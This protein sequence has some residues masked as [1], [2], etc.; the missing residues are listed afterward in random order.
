MERKIQTQDKGITII[1][2]VITII[3]LLIL[4]GI[5][6][7]MISANSGI[8]S[9]TEKAKIVTEYSSYK[10]AMELAEANDVLKRNLEPDRIET[11]LTYNILYGTRIKEVIPN[12][13]EDI[14]E[15]IISIDGEIIY[16]ADEFNEDTES[17]E[18]IGYKIVS[19]SDI[20]YMIELEMIENLIALS[21][22]YDYLEIGKEV[23]TIAYPSSIY[24]VGLK[25]GDGWNVLGDG[26][27]DGNNTNILRE[28]EE[29]GKFILTDEEK[30]Y[31]KNSP[32][33]INYQENDY[34]LSIKG[35]DTQGEINY[36]YS[37]NYPIPIGYISNNIYAAVTEKSEKTEENYGQFI[38]VN[39][40]EALQ[41]TE[42][43]YGN[44][45]LVANG[46]PVAMPLSDEEVNIN[47]QYTLSV[48]INGTTNQKTTSGTGSTVF[49]PDGRKYYGATIIAISSGME[50]Y[51]AWISMAEGY[52]RVYV[53][54]TINISKGFTYV[55]VSEYDNK[56]MHI[57]ITAQK[58][59]N[60][61]LYINGELK[62][63]FPVDDYTFNNTEIT[64]GDLRPGRKLF[65]NGNIYDVIA[66]DRILT[67]NEI[68]YTWNYVKK[69]YHIDESGTQY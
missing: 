1:S 23:E 17:L 48:L 5:V 29:L 6:L 66:Y 57:M 63:T 16:I 28:I 59:E 25:F 45:G 54:S 36:T 38:E 60:A 58:G 35:K 68:E 61:N 13:E 55:D 42:D 69:Q 37:Y 20:E 24:I 14:M 18:S 43:K 64:L 31:F 65:Y 44:I 15:R 53:Y 51:T 32:Y 30:S 56:F 22:K 4:S 9:Q 62:S 67:T 33:I 27:E 3:V 49:Y 12:V 7:A 47:E 19:T 10:E 41:Y 50:K 26:D 39:K 52:L 8:L 34:T 46:N 11:S 40:A 2:L 21:N